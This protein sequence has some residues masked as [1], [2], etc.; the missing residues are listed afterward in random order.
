MIGLTAIFAFLGI[1]LGL[2]TGLWW[3]FSQ[4]WFMGVAGSVGGAIAGGIGGCIFGFIGEEVPEW[5]RRFSK[6]HRVLGAIS[7]WLFVL[8]WLAVLGA[9][10]YSGHLFIRHMRHHA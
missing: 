1:L 4:N 5:I 8:L 10:Y 3:G 6:T 9:L 7:F 2:V